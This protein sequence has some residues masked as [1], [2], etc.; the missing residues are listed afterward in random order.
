[1][2]A[3]Q[4]VPRDAGPHQADDGAVAVVGVHARTAGL[5][6]GTADVVQVGQ[7]EL[8]VAVEPPGLPGALRRQHPVPA[9][10]LAG[11][12]VAH[13][14]VVAVLVELV[15]VVAGHAGVQRRPHLT[16]E[17][18]VAQSLRGDHFFAVTGDEEGVAGNV[19]ALA[20]GGA[21]KQFRLRHAHQGEAGLANRSRSER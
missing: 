14:E 6:R 18:L 16:G 8:A 12:V 9:D 1:V 2:A 20:G 5:D 4:H 19:L 15:D 7:V 11:A 21:D 3:E 17:H 13:H 10:D